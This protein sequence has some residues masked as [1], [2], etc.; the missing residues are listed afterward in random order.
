MDLG[1]SVFEITE[2]IKSI[3]INQDHIYGTHNYITQHLCRYDYIIAYKACGVNHKI[4]KRGGNKVYLLY[5]GME[6]R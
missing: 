1:I 3:I 2:L 5:I 6:I 4:A